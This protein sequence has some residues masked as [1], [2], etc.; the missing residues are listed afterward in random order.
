MYTLPSD[1]DS[2]SED[3]AAALTSPL[4]WAS[5]VFNSAI[6]GSDATAV[7]GTKSDPATVYMK[8]EAFKKELGKSQLTTVVFEFA[9]MHMCVYVLRSFYSIMLRPIVTRLIL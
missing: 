2:N 9:Y 4:S 1:D 8:D 7:T 6:A 3:A 5:G